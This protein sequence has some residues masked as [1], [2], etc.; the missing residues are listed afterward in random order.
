VTGATFR[1]PVGGVAGLGGDARRDRGF[2]RATGGRS[3]GG[4][5]V[6]R[7][8]G[9]GWWLP[10]LLV[11]P[12]ALVLPLMPSMR[13]AGPSWLLAALLPA[14]GAALLSLGVG[15]ALSG[16]WAVYVA[17]GL[18]GTAT[19]LSAVV[20]VRLGAPIPAPDQVTTTVEA[21]RGSDDRY[22]SAVTGSVIPHLPEV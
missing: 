12:V 6:H 20:A 13:S 8:I 9:I 1:N 18:L 17:A 21:S 16:D 5:S 2:G 15:G 22:T 14:A 11:A 19:M 3:C 4:S 7:G 10:V